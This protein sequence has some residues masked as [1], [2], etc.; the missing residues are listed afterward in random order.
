MVAVLTP[1][2]VT[3]LSNAPHQHTLGTVTHRARTRAKAVAA[4]RSVVAITG[5]PL[6]QRPVVQAATSLH[7][8]PNN[9]APTTSSPTLQP[10]KAL[11][12][13]VA[14]HAC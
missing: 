6:A 9:L 2:A 13:S 10:E 5:T 1:L 14:A 12:A 3:V 8:A 7:V 4:G 11:Q